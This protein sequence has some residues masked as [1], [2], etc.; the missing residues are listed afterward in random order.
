MLP[1]KIFWWALVVTGWASLSIFY[2][3]MLYSHGVSSVVLLGLVPLYIGHGALY[4][5]RNHPWERQ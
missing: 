1:E 3:G 2:C 5:G 4:V